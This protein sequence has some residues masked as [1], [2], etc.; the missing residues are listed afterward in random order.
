MHMELKKNNKF[1]VNDLKQNLRNYTP[2]TYINLYDFNNMDFSVFKGGWSYMAQ[3]MQN[4]VSL[5]PQQKNL[6]V[7]EFGS[8]DSSIKL[9]NLLS[10]KYKVDYTSF[11]SNKDFYINHTEINCLIYDETQ[12]EKLNIHNNKYDF[13]L[14]DGPCLVLRS[15][16]FFVIRCLGSMG[17]ICLRNNFCFCI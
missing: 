10:K 1:T 4:A 14:I 16:S 7:L 11:E 9:F 15:R 17:M 2:E 12:I 6:S 13:I 8:G 5:L 3:E